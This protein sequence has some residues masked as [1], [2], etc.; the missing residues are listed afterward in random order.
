MARFF[1]GRFVGILSG[2]IGYFIDKQGDNHPNQ[3]TIGFTLSSAGLMK[4]A[5]DSQRA[6]PLTFELSYAKFFDN[7]YDF[8]KIQIFQANIQWA[9]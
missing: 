8:R 4:K 6:F 5:D 7:D 2:R 9:L 3:A 1:G